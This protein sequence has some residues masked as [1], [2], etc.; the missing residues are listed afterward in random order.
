M[1][2]DAASLPL[3]GKPKGRETNRDSRGVDNR[4]EPPQICRMSIAILYATV[5]GNAEVLAQLAAGRLQAAGRVVTVHNV[6]DFPAARLRECGA[7]LIVASTWGDGAPPP[8]AVEFCSALE[9]HEVLRLPELRFAVF[10]LGSSSY[11]DFCGCGRRIDEDLEKCG[12]TR[13]LPCAE[14]DTKF[15]TAFENWLKQAEAVL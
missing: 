14:S 15:K 7:A 5:S 9:R 8:D 2:R 1:G 3:P 10:S 12:A 11:N 6:A 4:A 13:L